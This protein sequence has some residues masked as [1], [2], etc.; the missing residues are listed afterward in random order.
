[1]KKLHRVPVVFFALL[2]F[3]LIGWSMAEM[4]SIE[5][6][7]QVSR[8]RGRIV[9]HFAVLIPAMEYDS[10]FTQAY[11]SMKETAA[12]GEAAL[13]LFEYQGN[14]LNSI[15][16]LLT[17][18]MNTNPDGIIVSIPSGPS[19]ENLTGAARNRKIPVV[20]LESDLPSS[21][22]DAYVGTNAFELGRLAGQAAAGIVPPDAEIGVLLA[23]DG[24]TRSSRNISFIQGLRQTI[25]DRPM[26]IG[27]IRS[28][29]DTTAA[30]EE[31]IREI[32]VSHADIAAAV[33]SGPREAEGAAQALIEFGRVGT[34]LIIAVDD[35]PAI[36][37][38]MKMGV[39]SATIVRSPKEAG[40]A[41]MQTLIALARN[42][43]TS[44]YTDPGASI[45]WAEDLEAEP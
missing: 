44:V 35:N 29:R 23:G 15:E 5:R 33:F 16:P 13:Q 36:R 3:V 4:R 32:L 17:L 37:S 8:N 14:G 41:A 10:F 27:L 42:E 20:T 39:I 40:T 28:Y 7:I 9:F 11:N 18:I 22:R 6:S 19:S 31:F 12:A 30:G 34:P 1:M 43:R 21:S 26:D 25:R 38:L 2:F 24:D 45:L